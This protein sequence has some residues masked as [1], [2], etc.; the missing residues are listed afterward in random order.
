MLVILVIILF[1]LF[2]ALIAAVLVFIN[3]LKPKQDLTIEPLYQENEMISAGEDR[4]RK[5]LFLIKKQY[6]GILNDCDIQSQVSL[7]SL[8]KFSTGSQI[9]G[10]ERQK[11]AA[12]HLDFVF[13]DRKTRK[14]RLVI[15]LDDKSHLR[16]P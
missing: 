11:I 9:S 14:A 2:G 10:A 6:R 16:L 5:V 15:E 8:I 3:F 1:L 4:F 7:I 13:Y 12:K